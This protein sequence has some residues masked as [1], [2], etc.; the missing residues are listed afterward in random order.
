MVGQGLALTGLAPAS[1]RTERWVSLQV[2][3]INFRSVMKGPPTANQIDILLRDLLGNAQ[4]V[5][6]SI[7]RK[8]WRFR[9]LHERVLWRSGNLGQRLNRHSVTR[10]SR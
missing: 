2:I 9:H 10:K 5:P 8:G 3:L 6:G 4:E 7:S 1:A